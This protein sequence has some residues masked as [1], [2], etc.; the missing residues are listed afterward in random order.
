MLMNVVDFP[1][2]AMISERVNTVCAE[3]RR[4]RRCV[5][6]FASL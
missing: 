5:I 4:L 2:V 6:F 1:S 3:D